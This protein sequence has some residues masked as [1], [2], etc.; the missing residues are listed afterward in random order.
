MMKKLIIVLSLSFFSFCVFSNLNAQG[1]VG[2]KIAVV[3]MEKIFQE[4]Y[5]TKVATANLKKQAEV[6][7]DYADK[8]S[9]S[10][11]KLQEEFT[12]LRD[13]SQNIVLSEVERENKR[14]AAQDKYRQMKEKEEEYKQYS[15]DKQNQLRE[16]YEQQR[17]KLLGEVRDVILR[18]SIAEGYDMV[19]DISGKTL[20]NIS[21]VVYCK[22]ALDLTDVVIKEI[23][24]PAKEKFDDMDVSKD[25]S[26]T[27]NGEK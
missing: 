4:Y 7:K 23:N 21:L 16:Q 19:L 2:T 17:E 1:V 15:A 14:L 5:K 6:Y 18:R 20:N 11:K 9:A 13:E 22:P 25:K 3:D 24:L 12:K 10:L 27:K 26:K 8:L